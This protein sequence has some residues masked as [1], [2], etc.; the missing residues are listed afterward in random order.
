MKDELTKKGYF[1]T[2]V[3]LDLE[4]TYEY[5]E[6]RGEIEIENLV[7][8]LGNGKNIDL[9]PYLPTKIEDVI[10]DQIYENIINER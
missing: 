5:T 4:V 7:I 1:E 2:E 10:A 6:K 3:L 9:F 8:E